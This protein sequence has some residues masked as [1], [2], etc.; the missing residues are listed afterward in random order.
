VPLISRLAAEFIGTLLLVA[1]VVGSGIAA[2]RLSP[3]DRGLE[4]LENAIATAL[5]LFVLIA[6]LAPISGAHLNPLVSLVDAASGHQRWGDALAYSTAQ[7]L[8]GALGTVLANLMFGLSAATI[9]STTRLSTATALAELVATAG[10]VMVIF[11]LARTGRG[12]WT[13]AA[14]AAWIGGAYFFTSSTSFANPAVTIA[15]ILSDTFAGIAPLSAVG[16][17]AAQLAG[18]A[19]GY[20]I[21]RLLTPAPTTRG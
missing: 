12:H 8:G 15:R 21:V 14:V 3:S 17:V 10:L 1:T 19:V 18:A 20:G 7:L 9:S 13:P 16:F 11:V 6:V 5:I 2:S 4:L